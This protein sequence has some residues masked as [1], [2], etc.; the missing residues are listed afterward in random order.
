MVLKSTKTTIKNQYFP[1]FIDELE[2]V[3][4]LCVLLVFVDPLVATTIQ[5][6]SAD[7][8]L[9]IYRLNFFFMA[10]YP[11]DIFCRFVIIIKNISIRCF[12]Q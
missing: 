8:G 7:N 9:F 1:L 10:S 2:N 4:E 6:N 5:I 11:V 3:N 12:Q